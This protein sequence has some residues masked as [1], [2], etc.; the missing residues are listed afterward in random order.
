MIEKA[1]HEIIGDVNEADAVNLS[2]DLLG[3]RI[4]TGDVQSSDMQLP[5]ATVNL[6][7]NQSE[8][9]SNTSSVRRPGIRFK[10]W[11]D[12]HKS[13]AKIRDGIK[14]L[15]ENKSFTT[16]DANLILIRH[17]NDFAFQEPDGVWQFVIDFETKTE[18]NKCQ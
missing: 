14:K 10:V 8:F 4:V 9:R 17:E 7:S 1:I 18:A 15:F 12:D 13:G 3:N 6:E 5:Y 16:S 2:L 11:H